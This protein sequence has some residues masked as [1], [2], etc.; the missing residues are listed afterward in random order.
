[1]CRCTTIGQGSASLAVIHSG[2]QG[3]RVLEAAKGDGM[4][5]AG[6]QDHARCDAV[7]V[8]GQFATV[9]CTLKRGGCTM[10]FLTAH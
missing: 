7:P 1:M 5:P 8:T 10:C 2:A 4:A 9:V 3:L 6:M